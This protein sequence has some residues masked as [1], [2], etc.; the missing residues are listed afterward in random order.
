MRVTSRLWKCVASTCVLLTL[1][2]VPATRPLKSV[3]CFGDSL[4][5]IG[6]G[7]ALGGELP[8]RVINA[9]VSGETTDAALKRLQ[10]DVLDRHP[11]V[12]TLLYG[13]N[14]MVM[15]KPEPKVPLPR[16]RENLTAIIDRVKAAGGRVVLCTVPP[17]NPIPYF[18]RHPKTNYDRAGG[19]EKVIADYRAAANDVASA[20]HVPVVDLNTILAAR[21]E[22][23]AADGV[24]P[25]PEGRVI[26][27][28]AIAPAVR[29]ALERDSDR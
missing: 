12:V 10:H 25:T 14:D 13:T 4:T 20:E 24:H 21:P 8:D 28:K 11:D 22:W 27:A 29:D 3:V 18:T 23:M 2:S 7:D 19:L 16:F 5:K 15:D 26:I 1:S 6:F 9:G 17:I